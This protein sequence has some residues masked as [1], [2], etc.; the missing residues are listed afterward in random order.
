MNQNITLN[1]D[2]ELI[3]K[4]RS[5]ASRR[6][7]SISSMM[8]DELERLVGKA[9]RYEKAKKNAFSDLVDGYHLGGRRIGRDE[10]H[11]R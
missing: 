10:L 2:Q 7:Q 8:A 4:V 5:L 11:E 9:E 3:R 1:M 6:G